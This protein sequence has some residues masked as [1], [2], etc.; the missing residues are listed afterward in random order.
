MIEDCLKP[1]WFSLNE[2]LNQKTRCLL[3][4]LGGYSSDHHKRLGGPEAAEAR[5][6]RTRR[7]MRT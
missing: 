5:S 7:T 6:S 1:C 2:L 3:V 4:H